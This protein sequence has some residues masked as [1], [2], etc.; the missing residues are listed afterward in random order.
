M[1]RFN[2][3]G[4]PGYQTKVGPSTENAVCWGHENLR[5]FDASPLIVSTAIDSGASPTTMLRSGL[6]MAKVDASAKW[7]NYDPTA[8]DGRQVARGI[9]LQSMSMLN[10][11]T[12]VAEDKTYGEILIGGLLQAANLIN[13]DSLARIQL[14]RQ[15]MFDDDPT[16][17][18]WGGAFPKEVTKITN[19]VVLP[20]DNLTEFVLTTALG[21]FTLPAIGKGYRFKFRS[22]VNA[23]MGIVSAEGNNIVGLND[24]AASSATFQTAGQ[25]LGAACVVYSNAAGDKWIFENRSAGTAAVTLT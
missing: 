5:I 18:A 7:S 22:E 13:L 14:A 12:G 4:G 21:N 19:Y 20:A 11:N 17:R 15:F 8:T 3:G 6:V 2:L 1:S 10:A 16:G 23:A 25:M 9:L 24:V